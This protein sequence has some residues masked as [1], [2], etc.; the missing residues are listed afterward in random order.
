MGYELYRMIRDGAP[1]S[2]TPAMLLLALTIA[3]D[4]R[5]PSQG[6]P[7]DGGWPQSRVPLHG[8]WR[9]GNWNDG[10]TERTGMGERTISRALADLSVAGYEMR[11][12]VGRGS[13]GQIV[14]AARSHGRQFR[15][16]LLR[17]RPA[18]ERPPD[19]VIIG[20]ESL[21][22][23][24][25]NPRDSSPDLAS[26]DTERSPDLTERSPNLVRKVAKSGDPLS[27]LSP[28]IPIDDGW[29]LARPKVEGSHNGAE[30][31][32]NPGIGSVN[33]YKHKTAPRRPCP[34]CGQDVAEQP[35]GALRVH[36]PR[37]H[38]CRGSLTRP[39]P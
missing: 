38:R 29:R 22:D 6:M 31:V 39:A 35:G 28:T 5:D 2:W 36:G 16:P 8:Y 25:T 7:D 33:G 19:L 34:E 13:D 37:R 4:A 15:V 20:S 17:P 26:Y 1:A 32:D 14:F 12:A 23:L 21:S 24:A 27:P 3:D 10:L 9:D 30:S 18:P 11:E